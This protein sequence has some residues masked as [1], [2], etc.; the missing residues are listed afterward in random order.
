MVFSSGCC[1]STMH[2]SSS[3]IS[4]RI[5][6]VEIGALSVTERLTERRSAKRTRTVTVRP[7]RDLAGAGCK[8]CPLDGAASVGKRALQQA[9]CPALTVRPPILPADES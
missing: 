7:G 5:A 1:A 3:A 8:S 9:C 6:V 2:T 4:A